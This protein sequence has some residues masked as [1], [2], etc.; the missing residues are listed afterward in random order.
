MNLCPSPDL[1]KVFHSGSLWEEM[2]DGTYSLQHFHSVADAANGKK[3]G[4]HSSTAL[5]TEILLP[6]SAWHGI[7]AAVQSSSA[8]FRLWT[9]DGMV[10]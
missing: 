2:D 4:A 3:S 5:G 9:L 6:C 10:A 8:S 7:L 1:S